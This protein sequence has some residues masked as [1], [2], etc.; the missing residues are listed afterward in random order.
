MSMIFGVIERKSRRAGNVLQG[1]LDSA[2]DI[3]EPLSIDIKVVPFGSRLI[4]DID[5]WVVS[6]E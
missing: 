3:N 4:F 6:G 2:G 1:K 5:L